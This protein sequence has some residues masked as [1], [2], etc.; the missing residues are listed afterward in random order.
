MQLVQTALE[1]ALVLRGLSVGDA[2]V[3]QVLGFVTAFRSGQVNGVYF[4]LLHDLSCLVVRLYPWHFLHDPRLGQ[5]VLQLFLLDNR[6]VLKLLIGGRARHRQ[7]LR[8]LRV[9]L[10]ADDLDVGVFGVAPVGDGVIVSSADIHWL[11]KLFERP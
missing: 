8:S 10:N 9:I 2:A 6:F 4:F 3:G 11:I 1:D 5:I 7:G